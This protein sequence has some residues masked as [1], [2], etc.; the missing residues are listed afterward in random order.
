QGKE[1]AIFTGDT[2]FIGDV[3]RPDLAIKA[4]LTER[5]LAGLM[6]ESLRNKIMPL[7]DD[8]IVYPAHG[9][10]S[11]CGKKMSKETFDTLGNQ[12]KTNYALQAVTKEQFID[13]LLDGIM[14][15]PQYFAKNAKLNK[16]GYGSFDLVLETGVVPLAPK[17]LEEMVNV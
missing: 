15:A 2:L 4:D 13:Q 17:D 3:G 5:D 14:P 6:F 11:A 7:P 12:K 1:T 9:A 8:V 10:G 16:E